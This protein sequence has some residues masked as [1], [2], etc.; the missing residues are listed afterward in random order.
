M[1]TRIGELSTER[2]MAIIEK[3]KDHSKENK[4][5]LSQAGNL[6]KFFDVL[7]GECKMAL[8]SGVMSS[9]NSNNIKMFHGLVKDQ[10]MSVIQAAQAINDKKK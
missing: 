2:K 4:W 10:I 8:H 9:G 3:I 7:T 5:T 6:K 1:K